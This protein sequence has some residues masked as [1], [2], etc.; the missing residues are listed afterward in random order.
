MDKEKL[1][2][3]FNKAVDAY[4]EA[5]LKMYEWDSFY[6]GWVAEDRTGVYTYADDVYVS[7][8]DIIYIVDN[9]VPKEEFNKWY[10][11]CLW[12]H[13]FNMTIPTLPAWVKG[14]P[15]AS[16]SEMERLEK[17]RQEFNDACNEV[18]EGF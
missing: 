5:F 3:D 14:A 2:D 18:K 11:Y 8:S 13:D 16:E 17:M 9:D 10:S 15:R 12:A 6:G 1:K 7:L 4:L